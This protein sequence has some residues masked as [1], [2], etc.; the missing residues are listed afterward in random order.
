[1]NQNEQQTIDLV[2]GPLA[3]FDDAVAFGDALYG[4]DGVTR[5]A[6]NEFD[7]SRASF[8]FTVRSLESTRAALHNIGDFSVS[9]VDE[10]ADGTFQLTL[11]AVSAPPAAMPATEPASVESSPS[12]EVH[13]GDAIETTQPAP[14]TAAQQ[15]S[16]RDPFRASQQ[17]VMASP[18]V[19]DTGQFSQPSTETAPDWAAAPSGDPGSIPPLSFTEHARE[20]VVSATPTQPAVEAA[21]LSSEPDPYSAS[22][23]PYS[24]VAESEDYGK[25]MQPADLVPPALEPTASPTAQAG[26]LSNPV[27]SAWSSGEGADSVPAPAPVQQIDN[28]VSRLIIQIA[29]ELRGAADNLAEL[30]VR[31]SGGGQPPAWERQ[32]PQSW[33]PACAPVHSEESKDHAAGDEA[34]EYSA[35]TYKE[36]PPSPQP[37]EQD[38]SPEQPALESQP[39]EHLTSKPAHEEGGAEEGEEERGW[40]APPMPSIG[41]ISPLSRPSELG[42]S[43]PEADRAS[44][45]NAQAVALATAMGRK[46]TQVGLMATGLA[47]FADANRF[48]AALRQ[49]PGVRNVAISEL[50][51]G[52][53]RLSMDYFGAQPLEVYLAEL[54]QAFPHQVVKASA[55]EIEIKLMAA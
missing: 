13:I 40:E 43:Q 17:P 39:V 18:A 20:S 5:L 26:E 25:A 35:P 55:H 44:L 1:V 31:L 4:L 38:W 23:E 7:E 51:Q 45:A 28:E 54:Q 9:A 24:G 27:D 21:T 2:V 33:Q 30:A 14:E 10:L 15:D 29:G 12:R 16:G 41:A 37:I 34:E 19:E 48:I 32:Q 22:A 42:E 49:V 50:D 6:L 46:P 52:R 11:G 53:L 36:P 47:S 8:T 3:S